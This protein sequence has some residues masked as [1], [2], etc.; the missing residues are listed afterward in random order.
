MVVGAPETGQRETIASPLL[1]GTGVMVKCGIF[2]GTVF[3]NLTYSRLHP[4]VGCD[5]AKSARLSSFHSSS[6][7]S[8]EGG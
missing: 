6:P 4:K 8:R 1:T 2:T 5:L 3:W 7:C